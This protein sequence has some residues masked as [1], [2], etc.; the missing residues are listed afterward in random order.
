MAQ[1]DMERLKKRGRTGGM[2]RWLEEGQDP[3]VD[4]A[5]AMSAR[6]NQADESKDSGPEDGSARSDDH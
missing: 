3:N 5:E 4:S 1:I 6:K 2:D